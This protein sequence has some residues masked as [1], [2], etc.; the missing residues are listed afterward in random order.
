MGSFQYDNEDYNYLT[1]PSMVMGQIASII[2]KEAAGIEKQTFENKENE[3][4]KKVQ[5]NSYRGSDLQHYVKKLEE[6]NKELYEIAKSQRKIAIT[7]L[8]CI[9]IAIMWAILFFILI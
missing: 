4:A 3:E 9:T 6:T 7:G 8:V 2:H 1:I 5:P